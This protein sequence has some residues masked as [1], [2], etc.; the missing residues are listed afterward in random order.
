MQS[1][2][3]G[4]LGLVVLGLLIGSAAFAQTA[5]PTN[6]P[7]TSIIPTPVPNQGALAVTWTAATQYMRFRNDGGDV[8]VLVRNAGTTAVS[9]KVISVTD[10]VLAR[11]GDFTIAIPTATAGKAGIVVLGPFAPQ[12]FNQRSPQQDAGYVFLDF[13]A[14]ALTDVSVAVI[15]HH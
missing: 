9:V 7:Y 6:T 4:F 2:R 1:V 10:P 14:G 13:G 3:K 11:S 8:Q 15:K 5:T 12:G